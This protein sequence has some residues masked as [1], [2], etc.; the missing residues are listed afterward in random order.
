[1]S[2]ISKEVRRYPTHL[3]SGLHTEEI[4]DEIERLTA[5]NSRLHANGT[6]DGLT[7]DNLKDR[8]AKLERVLD[9]VKKWT[10]SDSRADLDYDR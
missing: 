4:A 3:P 9:A 8:I 1:M 6:K 2:D 7:I 5:S 10:E